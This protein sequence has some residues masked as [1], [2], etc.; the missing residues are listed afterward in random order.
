M[1]VQGLK[2]QGSF[3]I[4]FRCRAGS[5]GTTERILS[6][7][8]LAALVTMW[9]LDP[10]A[11]LWVQLWLSFSSLSCNKKV[12]PLA[13]VLGL[14]GCFHLQQDFHMIIAD[15]SGFFPAVLQNLLPCFDEQPHGDSAVPVRSTCSFPASW[16]CYLLSVS[17]SVLFAIAELMWALCFFPVHEGTL[18]HAVSV[19]ALWCVRFTTEV[20]KKLVEWLK[21]AFS[22]KTSTSAVRHAYLQ[23]MLASFKGKTGQLLITLGCG[24]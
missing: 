3:L 7:Q 24:A 22:L 1:S 6:F 10:P 21:K 13:F 17:C 18:V 15:K 8:G 9:F 16:C 12:R 4:G 23:C 2:C 5:L 11:K 14:L 19:L 20:P